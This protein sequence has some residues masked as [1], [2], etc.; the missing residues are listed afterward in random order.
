VT[1]GVLTAVGGGVDVGGVVGDGA[2]RVAVAVGT[3]VGGSVGRTAVVGC[4]ESAWGC[5]VGVGRACWPHPAANPAKR[6]RNSKIRYFF[7]ANFLQKT[8]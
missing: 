4:R 8:R 1:V 5:I 3:A 6:L 7:M 2:G